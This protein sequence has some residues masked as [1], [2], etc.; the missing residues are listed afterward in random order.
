VKR[1]GQEWPYLG[2]GLL[3]GITQ[4]SFPDPNNPDRPS[5][6]LSRLFKILVS[7]SAY[8]I[9]L[10]QC[11]RVI[12]HQN[13]RLASPNEIQ[14]RWLTAINGRLRI[15]RCMTSRYRYKERAIPAHVVRDTWTG[16]LMNEEDLPEE[17]EKD[18]GPGVLVGIEPIK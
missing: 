17:W 7:E 1:Q 6:A 4:V 5:Q 13:R 12:E 9:W 16:I 15:D 8:L 14:N 3:I 2:I 11:E 18:S 10:L